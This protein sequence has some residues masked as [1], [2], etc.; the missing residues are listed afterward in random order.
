MLDWFL[1]NVPLFN[2]KIVV[3]AFLGDGLNFIQ[4]VTMCWICCL[5]AVHF[6]SAQSNLG[7]MCSATQPD[8]QYMPTGTRTTIVKI[9]LI[10][11]LQLTLPYRMNLHYLI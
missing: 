7:K 3:T 5:G 6:G 2:T 11:H 1:I 8:I 9:T 4:N 10:L